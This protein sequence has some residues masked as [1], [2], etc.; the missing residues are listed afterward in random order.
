MNKSIFEIDVDFITEIINNAV[1][2]AV[3]KHV[4][5]K[6]D[7]PPLLTRQQLMELLDIKSTKASELLNR[8]DFPVIREFGHP[9]VP[10]HLLMKW[11]E[12]HTDW[13]KEHAGNN[14]I[15]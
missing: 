5:L 14:Y 15:L 9:R 11:I 7:L 13:V 3:E 8:E 10:T 6:S 1:K 4:Q 2:Q 12:E